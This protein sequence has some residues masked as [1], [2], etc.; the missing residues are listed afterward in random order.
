[1]RIVLVGECM[2]EMA[3]APQPGQFQLS[4]A[5]DTFNTAWYLRQLRPDWQVDYVTQVGRDA[6]SD[7]LVAFA[8]DHGIGTAHIARHPD[9]TLGLYLISL[10]AGERSFSYWRGQS[11]AKDLARDGAMLDASFDGADLI[12]ISGI[13]LAILDEAGRAL[14]LERLS[15]AKGLVAFDTNLRPKLWPDTAQMGDAMMQAARV[16]DIVLPSHDD[17]A[18]HFGDDGPE[19]TLER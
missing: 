4:F 13:T 2:V 3:P 17:E 16:S 5:G 19:A 11:A 18:E 15:Q 10:Q 9:R 8:Q 14:L 1:M 12:Y 7:Q 6:I